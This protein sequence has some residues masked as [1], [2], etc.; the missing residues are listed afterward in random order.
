MSQHPISPDEAREALELVE[1]T[2]RH[3]RRAVAHGGMPYFLLI[4]GVVWTL[5][6][7]STHFLG[8]GSPLAGT[9]WLVLDVLGIVASLLVGC[10]IG[11]RVRSARYGPAVGLFW[12]AWMVYGALIIYFA[13]PENDAQFSLLI[14]LFAMFGYVTTGIFYR[15]R[16]LSGLGGLV[17][18]FILG[19]Y[20]LIP[21]YFDLWMAVLGGGSLI[22]AGLYMRY[23]W[24]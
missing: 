23:A 4:W 20:L 13:Q 11:T 24:R 2:T 17:T 7:G 10:W 22:A 15:S 5:G 12:L 18:L 1:V 21:A 8:P 6:F 3:M 14:S 9:V 16:F 19:G